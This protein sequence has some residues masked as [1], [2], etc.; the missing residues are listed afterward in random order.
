MSYLKKSLIKK[1]AIATFAL[2][3]SSVWAADSKSNSEAQAAPTPEAAT[4]N[5]DNTS[6]DSDVQKI[7]KPEGNVENF[8]NAQKWSMLNP[9]EQALWGKLG[10]TEINWK[11][12]TQ[13]P[14]ENKTW[15]KLSDE[16]R[17]V[18]EQG[19]YAEET[20]N[21]DLVRK[22]DDN[23][24]DIWN[25]LDR[26]KMTPAEQILWGKLGWNQDSWE[27]K[28]QVPDSE[29]KKWKELSDEERDIAK[30]L[31]YDEKSWDT[32]GEQSQDKK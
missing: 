3:T 19:G 23:V 32:N 31:G 9:A 13:P 7:R 17:A 27:G 20:W 24:E 8:W 26:P 15:L 6:I 14:S 21:R 11:D 22:T 12:D 10:W 25:S 4:V 29:N 30:K 2:A 18:A 28:A 5:S 1:L 16:E